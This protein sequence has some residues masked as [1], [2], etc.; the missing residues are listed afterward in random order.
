MG[1]SLLISSGWKYYSKKEF[2]CYTIE[3]IRKMVEMV[4]PE[5]INANFTQ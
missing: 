2:L 4:K 1:Y 5:E 3:Q